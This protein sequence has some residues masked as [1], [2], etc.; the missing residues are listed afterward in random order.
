MLAEIWFW[1]LALTLGTYVVLGGTDLGVGILQHYVARTRD[2][3]RAV[4]ETIR[5]LWKPNEVWLVAAGGTLFLA[6]PTLLAVSFSGFYLPLMLVLWL[7]LGRGMGIELRYHVEDPMWQQFWDVTSSLASLLLAICFGAALGNILRGVPIGED[8]NFFAALWTNFR[9]DDAPGILDWYTL[10]VGVLAV[11]A[12]T[13]HGA[14]WLASRARGEVR[15]RSALAADCLL[16]ALLIGWFAVTAASFSVRPA[17]LD[18]VRARP[19]GLILPIVAIAALLASRRLRRTGR[20][21]RAYLASCAA[22]YASFL[23]AALSTYPNVLPARDPALSLTIANAAA[24][25]SSLAIALWWWLP[26][27]A[28]VVGCFAWV[29]RKLGRSS[30]AVTEVVRRSSD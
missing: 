21:R 3:R 7:L 23:T 12:L 26:G 15:E 5:P 19:A 16:P 1:L 18:A 8:G 4:I 14:V 20:E 6:F 17:V 9:V 25:A 10:L 13:Y 24:P 28:F 27:M 11:L 30:P 22:L 2:E 29:H